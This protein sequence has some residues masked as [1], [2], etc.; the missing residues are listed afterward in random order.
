MADI[1][2]ETVCFIEEGETEEPLVLTNQK[3]VLNSQ[4]ESCLNFEPEKIQKRNSK[5]NVKGTFILTNDELEKFGEK[6]WKSANQSEVGFENSKI[7]PFLLVGDTSKGLI[8]GKRGTIKSKNR[9][10]NFR[11]VVITG[12]SNL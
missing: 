8:K 12:L 7:R 6:F 11:W 10:N 1:K 9:N 5:E 3:I 4:S 2:Q